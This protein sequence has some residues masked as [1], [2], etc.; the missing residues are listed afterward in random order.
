[1]IEDAPAG[2][3][4][5]RGAGMKVI[6]MASTYPTSKLAE[7]DAVVPAFARLQVSANGANRL[8]IELKAV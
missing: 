2:V 7:A 5:A 3:R 6:G 8:V 4:A 1:M